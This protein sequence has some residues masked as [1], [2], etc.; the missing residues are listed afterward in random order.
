MA[1]ETLMTLACPGGFE[2]PTL[3]LEMLVNLSFNNNIIINY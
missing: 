3:G 2:P 1:Q